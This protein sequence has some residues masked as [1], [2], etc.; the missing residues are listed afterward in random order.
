METCHYCNRTFSNKTA[1]N[2]HKLGSCMWMHTSKK[3]KQEDVESYEPSLTDSQRDAFIRKLL[4]QVTKMNLKMT[5]MQKEISYL[6]RKQKL[7][8]TT[9]LNKQQ[10]K[11]NMELFQWVK[12]LSVSRIHLELVFRQSLWEGIKQ[13]LLDAFYISETLGTNIPIRCYNEKLNTLFVYVKQ[14]DVMKWVM[15]DNAMFRKSCTLIAS[16]FIELFVHWQSEND[17]YVLSSVEVQEQNMH[18]MQKAMD[19]SYNQAININKMI[20]IV[21]KCLCVDLNLCEFE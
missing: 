5:E 13:V 18:F 14:E 11:P 21:Y 20:E 2:R 9:E 17:D 4:L 10:L 7:Q 12:Q 16:K 19:T 15:C 8:I 1:L 3:D 6:K